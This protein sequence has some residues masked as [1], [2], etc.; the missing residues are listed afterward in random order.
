MFPLG[1]T[2]LFWE[3]SP[4]VCSVTFIP[5]VSSRTKAVSLILKMPLPV[6]CKN[7][8]DLKVNHSLI[9]NKE[10]HST[11][12]LSWFPVGWALVQLDTFGT[13]GSLRVHYTP[14]DNN[15]TVQKKS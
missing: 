7:N 10:Q 15:G 5:L 2:S 14:Y 12:L 6:I 11:M 1:G 3:K 4:P 9:Y 8:I 13:H